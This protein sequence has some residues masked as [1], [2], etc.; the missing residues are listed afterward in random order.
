MLPGGL[1][2]PPGMGMQK[3]DQ[4]TM[5]LLSGGAVLPCGSGLESQNDLNMKQVG[6]PLLLQVEMRMGS[7]SNVK[8]L[9]DDWWLRQEFH[10]GFK[11]VTR[12]S[13]Q[14]M[15]LSL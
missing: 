11:L 4:K 15:L 13:F 14:L 10:P 3:E 9:K 2:A 6:S 8:I 7:L 5:C 12:C 1:P